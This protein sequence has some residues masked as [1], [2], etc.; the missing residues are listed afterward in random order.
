MADYDYQSYQEERQ[1]LFGGVESE[2]KT[3]L[4]N[5]QALKNS[6]DIEKNRL[7][8][9]KIKDAIAKI[10]YSYNEIQSL[11]DN[12]YA[13]LQKKQAEA[14]KSYNDGYGYD[15]DENENNPYADGSSFLKVNF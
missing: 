1:R 11:D 8:F 15:D 2:F 7:T 6:E 12:Y 14:R 3:I 10:D 4:A 5:A 9:I 13:Q